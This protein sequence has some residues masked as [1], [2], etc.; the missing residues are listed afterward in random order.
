[1]K[2]DAK[3]TETIIKKAKEKSKNDIDELVSNITYTI[4]DVVKRM[5]PDRGCDAIS[6]EIDDVILK[7]IH[8]TFING[9]EDESWPDYDREGTEL[10]LKKIH[11]KI[12]TG[13]VLMINDICVECGMRIHKEKGKQTVCKICYDGAEGNW[14]IQKKLNQK[15]QAKLERYRTKLR[16]FGL[17]NKELEKI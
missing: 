8:T 1:M 17:T 5:F 3:Y 13:K 14:E 12:R 2:Y 16:E 6:V 11:G 10:I 9:P 7:T 4:R 15:F